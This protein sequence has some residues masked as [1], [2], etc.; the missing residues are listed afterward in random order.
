M[1]CIDRFELFCCS[2]KSE[3]TCSLPN[4]IRIVY[5]VR[6][7]LACVAF[8]VSS[9]FRHLARTKKASDVLTMQG[10]CQ[11]RAKRISGAWT[12]DS[13]WSRL[14]QINF[15]TT[16]EDKTCGLST[17]SQRTYRYEGWFA[18]NIAAVRA[19]C[20]VYAYNQATC[21]TNC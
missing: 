17:I 6:N 5:C 12:L 9:R 4:V 11:L 2:E 3:V 8:T 21:I 14:R 18:M 20:L 1:A 15:F 19:F 13:Q 7:V 10:G 16:E